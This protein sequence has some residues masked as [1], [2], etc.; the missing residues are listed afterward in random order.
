MKLALWCLNLKLTAEAKELLT[1]VIEH[2]P[3]H[4]QAKAMLFSIEQDG[5]PTGPARARPRRSTRPEAEDNGP[6]GR[7]ESLDSA[8]LR[9]PA[10]RLGIK[11]LPVI[12]DLPLPWR[13]SGPTSSPDTSIPCCKPIAPNAMTV[14]TTASFSLCPIKNR[15]DRTP[16]ALRANLDA[17]L[18][19][20]DPTNLSHSELL[21]STLRPHGNGAK[22][23]PIF[24]GSN[25]KAYKILAEWVNHLAAPKEEKIRPIC[26][27]SRGHDES[28]EVFAVDRN[29]TSTARLDK[30]A[31]AQ[32]RCHSAAPLFPEWRS[33]RRSH[34]PDRNFR[35]RSRSPA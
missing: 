4:N 25:D 15:A 16:D 30:A 12:F 21:S 24:P 11:D 20:V 10:Q 26:D 27:A 6:S 18:R 1:T 19:L 5:G 14:S 22:P 13:S 3:N 29:R 31:G 7:P 23:R 17:T 34:E 8:V 33:R 9:K 28:D 32:S 2:N 35:S